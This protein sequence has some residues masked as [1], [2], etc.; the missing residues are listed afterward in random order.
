MK[1]YLNIALDGYGKTH[2]KI[3]GVPEKL[4]ENTRLHRTSLSAQ[5]KIQRP[6]SAQCQYGRFARK[7][8]RKLKNCRNFC[9][10]ISNST[11]SI[12]TS[13]AAKQKSAIRSNRFRVEVLPK[14]YT[15]AANLTKRYG[16]RMFAADDSAKRFIKNVAYVG[17]IMTHYRHQ[18]ANFAKP[19]AWK[20]PCTAGETTAVIDYNGDVRACELLDKF[21]SLADFDYDFSALWKQKRGRRNSKKLT[22]ERLAGVRTFVLFTILCDIQE[23]AILTEVPKNYLT[24]KNWA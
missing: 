4:G 6:F 12:S 14:I 5:R 7:I 9:G 19:T 1:L 20:F 17:T 15:Q 21:S 23:N 8:I 22:A 13:F 10:K 3:R 11:G 18:H 24:R 16:E 2:D